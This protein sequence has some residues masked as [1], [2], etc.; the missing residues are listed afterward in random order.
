M[1]EQFARH[2]PPELEGCSGAVFYSG[3][4]AFSG[5]KDLYV[6]GLNPGGNFYGRPDET[7]EWHTNEV[8][9]KKPSKWSEY[10]CESWENM[11]PGRCRIQPSVIHLIQEVGLHPHEVPAS[12]VGFVRSP[13]FKALREWCETN[14]TTSDALFDKCWPFHREVIGHV[15]PK[16]ILCMGR[17]AEGVLRKKTKA[18]AKIDKLTRNCSRG[19]LVEVF[20]NNRGCRLVSV[21]H[22]SRGISWTKRETDPASVVGEALEGAKVRWSSIDVR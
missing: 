2:I 1:I 6:L 7:I 5:L 13:D 12:N 3:R 16:L 4:D 22:P 11:P 17:G 8:L 14:G 18:L 19:Y 15:K 9:L 10:C 21:T 20:Q